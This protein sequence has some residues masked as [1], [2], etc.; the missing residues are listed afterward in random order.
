[1]KTILSG[2]QFTKTGN[3][4]YVIEVSLI[5]G[6]VYKSMFKKKNPIVWKMYK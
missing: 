2:S 5:K 4:K 3:I 6:I 1:L